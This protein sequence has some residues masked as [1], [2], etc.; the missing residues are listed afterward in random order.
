MKTARSFPRIAAN[1]SSRTWTVPP[2]E[3]ESRS[4]RPSSAIRASR[5]PCSAGVNPSPSPIMRTRFESEAANGA[6]A[7]PPSANAGWT[8]P[9]PSPMDPACRKCRL[10]MFFMASSLSEPLAAR[11]LGCRRWCGLVEP[12]L[13]LISSRRRN[14][15]RMTVSASIR[16]GNFDGENQTPG[17]CDSI[18]VEGRWPCPREAREMARAFARISH[19]AAGSH[20]AGRRNP[21]MI[22]GYRVR[23]RLRLCARRATA[24]RPHREKRP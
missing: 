20:G 1:C 5:R 2:F 17:T 3:Y 16:T 10:A 6:S 18:E 7:T 22:C 9:M 21:L 4:I 15:P 23:R 14:R 11:V 12:I 24:G 13:A 19:T 8:S